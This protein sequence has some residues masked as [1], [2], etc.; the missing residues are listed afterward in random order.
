MEIQVTNVSIEF[1]AEKFFWMG[2]VVVMVDGREI[3]F[4][5]EAITTKIGETPEW[6]PARNEVAWTIYP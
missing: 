4:K 6:Y 1:I 5:V 2:E 3:H